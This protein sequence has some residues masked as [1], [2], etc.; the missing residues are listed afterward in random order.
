M[1]LENRG[2]PAKCFWALLC[3]FFLL[4]LLTHVS[5]CG[6]GGTTLSGKVTKGGKGLDAA[7]LT[8]FPSSGKDRSTRTDADGKYTWDDAQ[9]GAVTITVEH[10]DAPAQ[11]KDKTKTPVK[12]TV[13]KGANPFDID[14]K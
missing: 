14:I 13:K 4:G 6:G 7:I 2:K 3:G 11:Y 12:T 10:K 5:G 8:F 9:E 1:S